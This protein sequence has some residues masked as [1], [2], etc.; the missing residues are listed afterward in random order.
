VTERTVDGLTPA[1]VRVIA[2][3][4]AAATSPADGL[5]AV[6]VFVLNAMCDSLLGIAIDLSTVDHVG[7]DDFSTAM[8]GHDRTLIVRIVQAMLVGELLLSPLPIQVYERVELYAAHLGIDDQAIA[9]AR[10]VANGSLGL[11]E[12]DFERCGYFE[13]LND[14]PATPTQRRSPT[15]LWENRWD[16]RQLAGHWESLESCPNGSLGLAV[17]RFYRAR[18]FSFPGSL[19]SAPPFLAQHDFVHVLG[20]YGSTVESEIEVFGLIARANPDL[21]GFALLAMVLNLF[22]TGA[23]AQGAGGFFKRDAGHITHDAEH[24]GIRLGDAMGRGKKI[25]RELAG[26]QRGQDADLLSVD[27][28]RH[29]DE[30]LDVVRTQFCFPPKSDRAIAAGSI[31]PFEVGGISPYQL[32][33]GRRQAAQAGHDY[34]SWGSAPAGAQEVILRPTLDGPDPPAQ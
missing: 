22:E 8:A 25:A 21:G 9:T 28:F 6:Q 10:E 31:G 30:D 15:P 2:G 11:A 5:T 20:D 4:V 33:L 7:P 3:A 1:E 12:A 34:D 29:A 23:Q 13:D 27:W 18:G 24:M 32:R 19:G 16:D 14:P 26:R 17:W